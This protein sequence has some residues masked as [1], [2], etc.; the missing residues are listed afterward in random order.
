[1]WLAPMLSCMDVGRN[2][3]F[4]WLAVAILHEV[5]FTQASAV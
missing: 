4:G 3:M 5:R 2:P 1:V